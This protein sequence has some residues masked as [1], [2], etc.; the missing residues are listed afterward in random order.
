MNVATL[1]EKCCKVYDAMEAES[2]PMKNM[3]GF[4]VQIYEGYVT[5][6][7]RSLGE[8]GNYGPITNQLRKSQ[9][10]V[11]IR[12]GGGKSP[13]QWQLNFRPDV[14]T[15]Q[16]IK[17]A[18]V[19]KPNSRQE[20]INDELHQKYGNVSSAIASLEVRVGAMLEALVNMQGI[21]N[22]M[23]ENAQ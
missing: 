5:E 15:V 22:E 18:G 6:L 17:A 8:L 2:R 12:R 1:V 11:P 9:A 16:P 14:E 4:D 20:D 10:A 21:I 7:I 13:S 19:S 23:R 3:D